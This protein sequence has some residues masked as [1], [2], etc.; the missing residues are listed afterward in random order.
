[1]KRKQRKGFTLVELMIVVGIIIILAS[2]GVPQYV[3]Y[4]ENAQRAKCVS[5]LRVILEAKMAYA[6][7]N[8]DMKATIALN[9]LRQAGYFRGGTGASSADNL[10]CP[11][12]GKYDINWTDVNIPYLKPGCDYSGNIKHVLGKES[13]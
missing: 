13:N 6:A 12:G 1:M 2:L 9:N 5:N 8:P 10:K 3:N 7:S 4:R 11:S